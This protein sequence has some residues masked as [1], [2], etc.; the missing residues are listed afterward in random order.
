AAIATAQIGDLVG[1]TTLLTTVSQVDPIKAYFPLSEREYLAVADRVNR[2]Q[3]KSL[4]SGDPGLTLI[5]S[6]GSTCP[7]KGH[8]EA[9]DRDMDQATGTIRVSAEF[10]NPARLLRPGQFARVR[11]DTSTAS[12][13]LLV[14]QRA[15][16]E[17]Q[18]A[19]QVRIVG[20]DNKIVQ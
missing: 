2:G 10:P 18:D 4:W 3:S 5:L 14:P 6:D 19:S 1:P 16:T 15:V 17:L 9:A 11:A 7:Q 8:F 13:L 20:A 12:N